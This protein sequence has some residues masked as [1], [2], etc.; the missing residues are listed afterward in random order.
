MLD[1]LNEDHFFQL[2]RL[3]EGH[4]GIKLPPVKRTMVEGRLRKRMR[5]LGLA[6]LSEYGDAI[7][8][9]GRLGEEFTHL[10]DCVTTNKTDFFREPEHFDFLKEKGIPA[11]LRGRQSEAST[12]KFWSAAASI[13]AEAYTTAM[14]ASDVLEKTR[15]RF[16][17][18]GTDI[19]TEAIDQARRAIYPVEMITAIP[20][21]LQRQ[22][23]M[24]AR[25]A[26]KREMRFVPELRRNVSFEHL[27]LM[28]KSYAID[29]D[30]DVIF[31]RNVL[32]YFNKG[33][34]EAVLRRL[35][36]HVRLGGF[37]ILGHSESFAGSTLED[38]RQVA[39][40]IFRKVI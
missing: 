28:D 23:L 15:H 20:S 18:L 38:M 1:Q 27:N 11:I 16:V 36:D 9:H 40:T 17:V 14:V 29:R 12:L 39:P 6:N 8:E 35:C 33:T 32:I 37:L 7:F 2:T 3:I 22:F 25:N 34:Q 13:G 31:C 30:F 24:R 4:T 10:V 26:N 19:S 21:R 5:H